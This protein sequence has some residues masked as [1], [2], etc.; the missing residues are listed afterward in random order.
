M[1]R[2]NH[3]SLFLGYEL[4][5]K[6]H[7]RAPSVFDIYKI[8]SSSIVV[9]LR[10]YQFTICKNRLSNAKYL[11]QSQILIPE[12]SNDSNCHLEDNERDC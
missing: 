4:P 1:N 9:K 7:K 3:D 12:I 6:E 8:Y 10:L 11:P 5:R 2:I